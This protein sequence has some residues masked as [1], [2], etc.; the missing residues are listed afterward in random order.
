LNKPVHNTTT[1]HSFGPT[2]TTTA[3]DPLKHMVTGFEEPNSLLFFV[4]TISGVIGVFMF[5]LLKDPDLKYGT[6]PVVE[7]RPAIEQIKATFFLTF[8]PRMICL[9]PIFTFT[10][11]GMTM[12]ASWFT[13]QMTSS[14]VGLVMPIFGVAEFIGGFTIGKFIDSFG[15]GPGLAW[16]PPSP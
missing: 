6:T 16:C 7:S 14:E 11:V 12:W 10:G 1:N 4:L 5:L 9:L 3:P 15:R 8:K 2:T 13:R